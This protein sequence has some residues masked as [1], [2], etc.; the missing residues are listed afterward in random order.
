MSEQVIDRI[1]GLE[2]R[3]EGDEPQ[4]FAVGVPHGLTG[5]TVTSINYEVSDYGD[6]G[7]AW[8]AVQSGELTIAKIAARAVAEVHYTV[9]KSEAA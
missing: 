6:H 4:Y 1:L 7:L 9:P 3:L 8:F 2:P 5:R